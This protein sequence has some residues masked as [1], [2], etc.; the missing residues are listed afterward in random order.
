MIVYRIT[1]KWLADD[2][3]GEG[4]KLYGGRWNPE[5]HPVVYTSESRSLAA[6][7]F[8]AHRSR[9]RHLID[10]T[11]VQI[12]IPDDVEAKHLKLGDLPEGWDNYPAPDSL[13][14]IG[15]EWLNSK[16]SLSLIVP[17]AIVPQ[18]SNVLIN[19]AHDEMRRVFIG[20]V[21]EFSFDRRFL[22]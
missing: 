7:E 15:A 5:G 6:L 9:S 22:A 12:V 11:L 17:S 8:Y 3:S 1:K 2:L 20:E 16:S 10:L 19:P 4:A 13:A 21:E 14:L 18:E